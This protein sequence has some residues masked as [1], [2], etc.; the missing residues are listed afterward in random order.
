MKPIATQKSKST[1]Q[2]KAWDKL[3]KESSKAFAAFQLYRNQGQNRSITKVS[4][5]LK[6]SRSLIQRWSKKYNWI[7][8]VNAWE[9][10]LDKYI[11][12]CRK[13][14][15][16][17]MNQR[18]IQTANLI[19]DLAKKKLDG[20]KNPEKELT[21]PET[22]RLLDLAYKIERSALTTTNQEKNIFILRGYNF[23]KYD[24]DAKN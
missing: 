10:F 22:I 12:E 14:E 7:P 3:P 5:T 15:I 21:I 2:T 23:K 11:Q 8:R 16:E 19:R 1:N 6:K 18:Q 20:I 13:D 24:K 4:Q 9:R 17:K